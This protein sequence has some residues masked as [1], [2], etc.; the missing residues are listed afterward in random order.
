MDQAT[1]SYFSAPSEARVKYQDIFNPFQRENLVSQYTGTQAL[2]ML[3]QANILGARM[4]GIS[5]LMSSAVGGYQAQGARATNQAQ[6][7]QQQYQNLFGEYQ[8]TAPQ[9]QIVEAGGRKLLV[10]IDRNGNI[11][12]KVD[13]GSAST[14]G[15]SGAGGFDLVTMETLLGVDLNGDGQI[16]FTTGEAEGE[17]EEVTLPL[18]VKPSQPSLRI[19]SPTSRG[20]QVTQPGEFTSLSNDIGNYIRGGQPTLNSLYE[21]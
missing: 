15:G 18:S 11:I 4:G 14:G 1:Q 2:P 9:Q 20:S 3:S 19:V 16:G 17:W 6:L 10:S 21:Q 12:N 7:A 8:A 13:L 5:D